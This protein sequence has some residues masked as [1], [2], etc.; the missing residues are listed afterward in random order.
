MRGSVTEVAPFVDEYSKSHP[1]SACLNKLPDPGHIFGHTV[2]APEHNGELAGKRGEF[3][4][5]VGWLVLEFSG[6]Q[7]FFARITNHKVRAARPPSPRQHRVVVEDLER[8]GAFADQCA[9]PGLHSLHQVAFHPELKLPVTLAQP[10][11]R[12]LK[13]RRRNLGTLVHPCSLTPP[14]N[15]YSSIHGKKRPGGHF[16]P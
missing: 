3:R 8:Q 14:R 5:L 6:D 10:I 7:G 15:P 4:S 13:Q 1:G 2:D 11:Q 16:I 12:L 9:Q